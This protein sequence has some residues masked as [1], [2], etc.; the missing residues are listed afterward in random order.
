MGS[1][2]QVPPVNIPT[3][4]TANEYV[5]QELDRRLKAIEEAD[6]FKGHAISM[7]G[8]LVFG[9]DDILRSSVERRCKKEQAERLVVLLTT[10]GG[11]AE[12]VQ[13]RPRT[14]GEDQVLL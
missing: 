12:T 4:A 2:P 8:P 6:V 7:N 14:S 13:K 11:Y 5:E 9:V 3:P 1:P 10:P